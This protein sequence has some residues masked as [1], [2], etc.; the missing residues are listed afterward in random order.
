MHLNARMVIMRQKR[1]LGQKK[2]LIDPS[3]SRFRVLR[4]YARKPRPEMP[5]SGEKSGDNIEL[6]G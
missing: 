2:V 5:V 4:A 3:P 6:Y 1:C